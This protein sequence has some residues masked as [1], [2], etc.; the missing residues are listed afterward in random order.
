[1]Q[2]TITKT[3]ILVV[4][5]VVA[6]GVNYLFAA[7]TG[8]TQ[9]PTGGNTSTPVHIGSTDQVKDGGL[10]LDGLSVFGGGYFQGS[11]GI[12]E[13]TPST[14]GEQDLKLDVD[15]AI[16]AKYYCDADG[17]NCASAPLGGSNSVTCPSGFTNV[18]AAGNQLGC[19]Q[20]DE[21]NGGA[22][23]TWN[24]ASDFCFDNFGGRLPSSGE[25]YIA[26]AN[27]NL[28]DE[29]D[30]AEWNDGAN[31]YTE[32]DQHATSGDLTDIAF[33][34]PRDDWNV[35][36]FRCWIPRGYWSAS[37]SSGNGFYGSPT[38]VRLASSITSYSVGTTYSLLSTN[39]TMPATGGP[40]RILASYAYLGDSLGSNSYVNTWVDDGLGSKIAHGFAYAEQGP[41]WNHVSEISPN[42]YSN[43]QTVTFILKL[44]GLAY[45]AGSSGWPSLQ[46][47]DPTWMTIQVIKDE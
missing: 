11:V 18:K 3:L 7:W 19:M 21:A 46:S 1:M 16:G 15:G 29:N 26:M 32:Y 27:Y 45:I 2:K 17:N 44:K 5:L 33:S 10:S 14:G 36:T 39:V 6:L 28:N 13:V 30:D 43:G 24:A 22:T 47:I 4:V 35:T 8:P 9:A 31:S 34:S 42:T 23:A 38:R 41:G 40:F 12:N 37:G 25:W 20:N